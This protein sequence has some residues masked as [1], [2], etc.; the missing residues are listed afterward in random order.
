MNRHA[1]ALALVLALLAPGEACADPSPEELFEQGMQAL[2]A[3]DWK[4]YTTIHER[5]EELYP[6][7]KTP[8]ASALRGLFLFSTGQQFKA[9]ADLK[10]GVLTKNST[11]DACLRRVA[12]FTGHY[13]GARA[14]A[15]RIPDAAAV[16]RDE[17]LALIDGPYRG[18]T[19]LAA[20]VCEQIGDH[21]RVVTSLGVER[22]QL[23]ARLSKLE[24]RKR[25]REIERLRKRHAGLQQIARLMDKVLAAFGK[26]CDAEPATDA[27]PSVYVLGTRAEFDAFNRRIG[28]QSSHSAVGFHYGEYHA[29]VAY[30][31]DRAHGGPSAFSE[32]LGATLVHEAFHQWLGTHVDDAPRWF[33]E[34]M[35]EYFEGGKITPK[36]LEI[37]VVDSGWVSLLQSNMDTCLPVGDLMHLGAKDFYAEGRVQLNYAQAWSWVHFLA[38]KRSTRKLLSRYFKALRAGKDAKEAYLEAFEDADLGAL[39]RSWRQYVLKLR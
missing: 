9:Y 27:V 1:L 26:L 39:E 25:A 30:E 31:Q 15:M 14:S 6:G 18:E 34:G 3:E 19:P 22:R 35:A 5:C 37:G 23:E 7:S 10:R 36:S 4:A 11:I 17:W 8:G 21:A 24:G 2:D 33:N 20:A 16:V 29:I 38:A 32:K 28:N 13:D 12:Y